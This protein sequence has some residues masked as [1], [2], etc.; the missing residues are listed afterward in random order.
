MK[1]LLFFFC[2]LAISGAAQEATLQDL[3]NRKQY[4]E[5]ISR[6]GE[7]TEDDSADFS[8]LYLLG[9]S[10]EGLLRYR[11]AYGYYQQCLDMAPMNV[12]ILNTIAR[13]AINLGRAAD[14]E[15]Y[16]HQV[17]DNDSTNFYANYQLARLYQ[18][19]GDYQRA[20]DIYE[21]LLEQDESNSTLMR[22]TGDCY[23]RLENPMAATGYYFFA[24]SNNRENAALAST[25]INSML[26]LGGD[27]LPDALAICDTA[28][29]YNPNNRILRQNKGMTLYMNK[30][31]ASADSLFTELITEGDSSAM[32]VKYAAVSRYYAGKY[33]DSVDLLEKTY[34]NDTTA[35]DVNLL[36][37]SALGK[38]YDRKRAYGHFDKA[39]DGMKPEP[40]YVRQLLLFRAET[41]R[42]D[43][44]FYESDKLLYQ[45]WQQDQS[46][47][48]LLSRISTYYNTPHIKHYTDE[49]RRKRGIFIRVLFVK[50]ALKAQ[51]DQPEFYHYQR[52]FFESLYEDMFFRSV[53][54][55]PLLAPDGR[56]SALNVVDLRYLINQMPEI[57]EKVKAEKDDDQ[58]K[59]EELMKEMEHVREE[60]LKKEQESKKG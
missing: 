57:P 43:A 17:L 54:E 47:L 12:D 48:D 36:L 7:L 10:Y 22:N 21:A 58:K 2:C 23:N 56:K 19:T 16:F 49:E 38:T 27:Y 1:K 31:Y 42:K 28:L 13:I 29:Y 34:E 41:L 53:T 8:T 11:E 15:R 46:D 44:R 25:L 51:K 59:W 35:V 45:A 6:A 37:G 18:Q 9:Q 5:A 39:E 20:I 4:A 33:L 30:M 14:A 24:Y 3:V 40:V 60:R 55:E 52:Y 50:E 26:R 32:T